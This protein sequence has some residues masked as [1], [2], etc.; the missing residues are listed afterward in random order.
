VTGPV[1]AIA[2]Y[3]HVSEAAAKCWTSGPP[4]D[5][6]HH[7]LPSLPDMAAACHLWRVAQRGYRSVLKIRAAT[8]IKLDTVQ[9]QM[10]EMAA[11]KCNSS[12][13][14]V[15]I[16]LGQPA[17][18]LGRVAGWSAPIDP[19]SMAGAIR[20]QGIPE[21]LRHRRAVDEGRR[22]PQRAASIRA[23]AFSRLPLP[24]DR[25]DNIVQPDDGATDPL[26]ERTLAVFPDPRRCHG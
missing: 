14:C 5:R 13:D 12:R 24:D 23:D 8:M 21:I 20:Q 2:Q 4:P 26:H 22:R 17:A 16:A 19:R 3:R 25:R 9:N 7:R 15:E 1:S 10:T 6:R 11:G 18:L